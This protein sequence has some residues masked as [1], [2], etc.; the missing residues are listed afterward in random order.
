MNDIDDMIQKE[1]LLSIIKEGFEEV[2]G[3]KILSLKMYEDDILGIYII[4]PQQTLS[5]VQMPR[6]DIKT[7]FYKKNIYIRELG[8]VLYDAYRAGS[9]I[10][11]DLLTT[12]SEIKITSNLFSTLVNKCL[13]NPPQNQINAKLIE[14]IELTDEVSQQRTETFCKLFDMYKKIDN[15]IN[16]DTTIST[17]TN[18]ESQ[19]LNEFSKAI[20]ELKALK[21]KKN[22]ELII[23][24]IDEM[25]ITLQLDLYAYDDK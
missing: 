23:N 4:P 24:Q 8:Q 5:F 3:I 21:V 1:K 10:D 7:D 12:P 18:N 19:I 22:S 15:K 13:N 20:S 6:F 11:Y 14:W 16:I 17:Q 25:Y 9:I 2:E